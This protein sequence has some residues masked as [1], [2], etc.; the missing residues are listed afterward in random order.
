MGIT[1]SEKLI[2]EMSTEELAEVIETF[3]THETQRVGEINAPLFYEAL[4]AIFA[5]PDRQTAHPSITK[6]QVTLSPEFYDPDSIGG[7]YKLKP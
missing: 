2:T 6:L 4:E 3:I 1:M 5:Q 7:G